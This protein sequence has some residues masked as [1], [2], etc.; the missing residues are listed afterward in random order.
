M[1]NNLTYEYLMTN[2]QNILS[3]FDKIHIYYTRT[4]RFIHQ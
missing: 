1:Y 3:K 2:V 4:E